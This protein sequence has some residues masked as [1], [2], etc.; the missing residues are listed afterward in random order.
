MHP[1]PLLLP[2]LGSC[3]SLALG[4]FWDAPCSSFAAAPWQSRELGV[5]VVPD[6]PC[7]S[8]AAAPW[9][10]REFGAGCVLGC[11]LL[12]FCCRTLAVAGAW[13][14]GWFRIPPASLFADAVRLL[15]K[16]G[17][18]PSQTAGV[19]QQKRKAGHPGAPTPP[20][21]RNCRGAA[22]KEDSRASGSVP[23]FRWCQG[24]IQEA[25]PRQLPGQTPRKQ[26]GTRRFR[27]SL[28]CRRPSLFLLH[29][30]KAHSLFP[31]KKR[32]GVLP[33]GGAAS[34]RPSPHHPRAPG[35]GA[36][37][38][39]REGGGKCRP[40]RG[41]KLTEYPLR[42][43][44]RSSSEASPSRCRESPPGRGSG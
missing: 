44:S 15:W 42:Q 6:A 12:L 31:R 27:R 38:V 32:K 10:L 41:G 25:K 14:W 39:P 36:P 33:R 3:G 30:Q 40:P 29:H 26:G 16:I 4:V 34:P 37:P 7:S 18:R 43:L 35:R 11:S 8:F 23:D 17:A 13:C 22:A 24:L 20:V 21:F 28:K 2:H 9:Q 5:G 19:R 1:A